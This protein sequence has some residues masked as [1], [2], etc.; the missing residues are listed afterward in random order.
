M[1]QF[2]SS[3]SL[4]KAAAMVLCGDAIVSLTVTVVTA[5]SFEDLPHVDES[6]EDEIFNLSFY[7]FCLL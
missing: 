3:E 2:V 7:I 6:L 4:L 1:K 5:G